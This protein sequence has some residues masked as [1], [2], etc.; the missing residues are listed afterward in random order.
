MLPVFLASDTRFNWLI[1]PHYKHVV[2]CIFCINLILSNLFLS[3]SDVQITNRAS[4]G[5]EY[6][7]M[8]TSFPFLISRG[9]WAY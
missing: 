5:K 3:A 4:H 8:I 7:M 2:C 1:E 6:W 9:S